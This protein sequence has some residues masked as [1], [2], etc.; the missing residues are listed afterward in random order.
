MAHASRLGQ[1]QLRTHVQTEVVIESLS[2]LIIRFSVFY[3]IGFV[4]E[5]KKLIIGPD[6]KIV[7]I[8]GRGENESESDYKQ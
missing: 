4:G 2:R 8:C 3:P 5:Q 6:N 7:N 1:N